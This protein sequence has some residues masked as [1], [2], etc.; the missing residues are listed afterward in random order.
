MNN[1]AS[2]FV[3]VEGPLSGSTI[4]LHMEQAKPVQQLQKDAM[5]IGMEEI[6]GLKKQELIFQ[7]L[8][9]PVTVTARTT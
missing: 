8:F 1:E 7:L 2:D 3:E 5:D 9:F 6:M 4:L